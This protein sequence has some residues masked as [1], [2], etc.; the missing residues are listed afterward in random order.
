M[1]VKSIRFPKTGNGY[2]YEKVQKP[3][4]PEK[5]SR[6]SRSRMITNEE[7]YKEALAVYKEELEYYNSHK[8]EYVLPCSQLL[9]GKEFTFHKDKI[10]VIF[11][12]NASGKSTILKAIAGNAA[13]SD[14]YT[15]VFQPIQMGGVVDDKF[16][17]ESVKKT[18]LQEF[19]TNSS[20]IKWSGNPI[21]FENFR[22]RLRNSS[23]EFGCLQGSILNGVAD[24]ALFHTDINNR[25]SGGQ[26]NSFILNRLMKIASTKIS[27][28]SILMNQLK[29][30]FNAN[31]IWK[32]CA[33]AQLD[34]FSNLPD[35]KKESNATILLDENDASLDIPTVVTLYT[36]W[37]PTLVEK[38]GC[39][40]ILVSHHPVILSSAVINN[41]IYNV[42]PLLPDYLEESSKLMKN[43]F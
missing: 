28:E 10:N 4:K 35:F 33:K 17:N 24:E 2:I 43:I 29:G 19:K 1:P 26:L 14:G 27:L 42:I 36:E 21:F 12:P 25:V 5:P 38:T 8:G 11:G 31:D 39:Q 37:L 6:F 9:I 40:L 34:Y 22:N 20:K 23:H 3:I 13:C 16:D 32:A 15:S 7:Q 30:Y 18:I 41:P